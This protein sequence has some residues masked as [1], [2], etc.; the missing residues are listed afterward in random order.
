MV[1]SELQSQKPFEWTPYN[2][3]ERVAVSVTAAPGGK[4]SCRSRVPAPKLTID[5][6]GRL[7]QSPQRKHRQ[8]SDDVVCPAADIRALEP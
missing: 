1:V 6:S 8:Q 2:K 4:E 7:R 5:A 3:P